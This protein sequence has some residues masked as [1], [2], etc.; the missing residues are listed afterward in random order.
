MSTSAAPSRTNELGPVGGCVAEPARQH[1]GSEGEPAVSAQPVHIPAR[2]VAASAAEPARPAPGTTGSADAG[3]GP[4]AGPAGE[5]APAA[6]SAGTAA[7]DADFE[8]AIA[9]TDADFEGA[10]AAT[11][12]DPAGKATAASAW[13]GATA[14]S[15]G[16][17][18]PRTTTADSATTAPAP[19]DSAAPSVPLQRASNAAPVPAP[20]TGHPVLREAAAG[21]GHDPGP[22]ALADAAGTDALLRCWVR[23][24]GVARPDNGVLRIPLPAS[25]AELR[26]AVDHWSATGQ[27]RFGPAYL[28]AAGAKGPSGR[29]LTAVELAALLA[30]EGSD[31][32]A[33]P[34]EGTDLVARVADSVRRTAGFLADRRERPGPETPELPFLDSEQALVLG[35]ALH[36]TPKGREGLSEGESTAYSPELRGRFPLHWLGVDRRLLATDSAWTERGR[37]VAAADVLAALA[38]PGLRLPENVAPLP[39]HPWQARDIR[40]RPAVKALFDAGLLR[41]LGPLGEPWHPTSSV[42]TVYRPGAAAM[43]KLSLGLRITNSRRE[44]LR[45]ELARGTEV[46]RLLRSG[47]ATQWQAVHPGFDIVRDPAWL[48]VDDLDGEPVRGLDVVLRHSPFGVGDR[49]HCVAGLVSP[50]PWP[51]VAAPELRSRLAAVMGRL[52]ERTRRPCAAVAAEWFLRY[53]EA[54]VRPVLWLDGQAGIALEAH[55]QNTLVLLDADGWPC[56]GRYRDNQGY[57]FR[58]SHRAALDRRLPGIGSASDTF[59]P[60]EVADERFAYYVG[61]NNVFGLIGAFGAQGLADEELLLAGFRRFLG[62]ATG[63]GSSL[64]ERLL[65]STHLRSK[66]NLLTRLQGMDELVG[67]VDTQSVYVTIPNPL[68]R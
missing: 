32:G 41:D 29:P 43:L 17:D 10:T 47:L 6:D 40:H 56:G 3:A 25:G 34:A 50:R 63:H 65:T 19:A 1:P 55:Q 9:A 30:R 60:D 5:D 42:R 37:A 22:F 46:H 12:A 21:T 36:P 8:G 48:A 38:G 7:T 24:T 20:P 62:T 14:A 35:H 54:V 4:A 67:P 13:R 23:E 18:T 33:D 44:N 68:A 45:K 64:P 15:A 39:L 53:L 61:I 66:A 2:P 31:S 27:H 26:T 16:T 49:A 28:G 51:G 59:V 57:Y 52:A 11:D 58:E